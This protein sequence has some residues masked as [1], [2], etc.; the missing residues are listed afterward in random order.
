MNISN[1][2]WD[3][4]VNLQGGR[5]EELDFKG[6]RVLGTYNRIDGKVGNTHVCL[7]SFDKEGESQYN[8]PFHGLVRIAQWTMTANAP[9]SLS[10]SCITPSSNFYP[11]EFEVIQTFTLDKSFTHT[12][13]VTHIKGRKVPLNIGYHYYWDT[14]NG[15]NGT[16]IQKEDRTNDIKTNGFIN[17]QKSNSIVFPHAQ[18]ELVSHGFRSAVLWTSFK[19]SEEKQKEFSQ[20]FCCIEPIVQWPSYFGSEKSM[21]HPNETVSASVEIKKVV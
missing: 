4:A 2:G 19:E 11:A 17:L 16:M 14:P 10:I 18:Y 9:N 21:I 3:I 6:T 15:W 12:V 8:L 13:K 1:N 20:D 5:I 7:P